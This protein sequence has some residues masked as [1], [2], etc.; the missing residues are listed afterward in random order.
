MDLIKGE[1][2]PSVTRK[3]KVLYYASVDLVR[4][5][6]TIFY[7]TWTC[8]CS[9]HASSLYNLLNEPFADAWSKM[10]FSTRDETTIRRT[11][12]VLC[13]SVDTINYGFPFFFLKYTLRIKIFLIK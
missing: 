2:M 3:T 7:S 4:D 8:L 13:R 9:N 12:N 5:E 10:I 11:L 1:R 6:S